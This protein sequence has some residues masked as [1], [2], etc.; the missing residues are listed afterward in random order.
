[1]II[2]NL[3]SEINLNLICIKILNI[4]DK[5]DKTIVMNFHKKKLN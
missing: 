1:M 3:Q 4:K 5:N 2:S